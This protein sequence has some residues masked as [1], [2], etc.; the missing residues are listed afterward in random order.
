MSEPKNLILDVNTASL[1]ELTKIK[2]IGKTIAQRI[3]N[4]RP[5]TKIEDLA[6]VPGISYLK[7]KSIKPFLTTSL[8]ETEPSPAKESRAVSKNAP[9]QPITRVGGTEAF[10]FL[11]DRN[12]RQD[13]FLI[14]LAG[15]I[16]GVFIFML[17]RPN[18]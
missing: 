13:A 7:L 10:V 12:E 11:E 15:F 18:D 1:E 8:I 5:Y 16:I 4:N 14:I 17:T 9:E 2:G 3:I 6:V